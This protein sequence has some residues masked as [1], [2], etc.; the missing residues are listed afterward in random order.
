MNFGNY[1]WSSGVKG[2]N[3]ASLKL[4]GGHWALAPRFS[5]LVQYNIS[6]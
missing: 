5:V 6:E 3:P 2:P 4:K 1:E